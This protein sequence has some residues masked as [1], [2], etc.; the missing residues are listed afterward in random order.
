[1]G[2]VPV[3]VEPS[4]AG[5]PRITGRLWLASA[6]VSI[7]LAGAATGCDG[8]SSAPPE[9]GANSHAGGQSATSQSRA[10]PTW[11][12][13]THLDHS[14]DG[15]DTT[16]VSCPTVSF[17]MAVDADDSSTFLFSGSKWSSAPSIHDPAP[18]TRMGMA[19]VSCSSPSF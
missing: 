4:L 3:S 16:S 19:S 13:A 17:C 10:A 14:Q 15:E 12:A 11:G 9:P 2:I 7:L 18:N 6:C 8:P 1:M 5:R